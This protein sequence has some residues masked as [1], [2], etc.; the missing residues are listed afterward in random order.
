MGIASHSAFSGLNFLEYKQ[1]L[2][3]LSCG[4]LALGV[5]GALQ[6]NPRLWILTR[7]KASTGL[8]VQNCT[9]PGTSV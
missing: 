4:L 1:G 2:S 6:S 7:D 3:E 9:V 5:Y 8:A